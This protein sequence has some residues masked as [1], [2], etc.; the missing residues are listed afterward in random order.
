[1]VDEEFLKKVTDI[2][3]VETSTLNVSSK[4]WVPKGEIF[5][6]SG[7]PLTLPKEKRDEED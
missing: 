7:K 5:I 2:E 4:N 1:M 6:M 3:W